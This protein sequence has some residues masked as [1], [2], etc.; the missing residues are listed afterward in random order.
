[1]ADIVNLRQAR[2]RKRRSDSAKDAAANRLVHGQSG[3]DKARRRL[4]GEL[5]HKRLEGH[6]RDRSGESDGRA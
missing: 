5:E 3:S 6:R 1:M 2:K 4:T